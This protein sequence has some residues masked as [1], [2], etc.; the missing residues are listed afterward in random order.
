LDR[1]IKEHD[2]HCL[3]ATRTI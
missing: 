1:E 3:Q 2:E